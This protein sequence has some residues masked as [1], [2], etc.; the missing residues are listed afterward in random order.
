MAHEHG[1]PPPAPASLPGIRH[2]IAIGSGKGG[3]GKTT[4]AVNLAI[5][6]AAL[7]QRVGLID[8]DIYGPNVPLMFGTSGQPKVLPGNQI[9]PNLAHGVKVMSVGLISPGDKPMV[10]RGP[11]LHQIIRQFLQQVEWGELDFLLVDLP[12]GTGD[13]VISLVQTV[14]LT[15]AV[16]VSTPSDVALQ[17]ARKALE[18]F[19]QVN[20]EI[21]GIVEN[22]SHFTCPHCHSEIDIFHK[23]GAVRT[24]EQFKVPF[25]GSVE[26][27]PAIREGGDNGA[28]ITTLGPH[29]A[30]AG[31]FFEI[32][33]KVAERA[34]QLEGKGEDI[35]E[36]Q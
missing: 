7:G 13:I 19:G 17:D 27:A 21:I 26:L 1:A 5:A 20:V 25:L 24:A 28:P 34:A 10:M 22:M 18:M 31:E 2:I 8:A 16:V 6:L 36:I 12:P 35:F 9:E 15:G 4:V 3:V 29:A 23:G 11:M 33:R 32:A 14:P 30:F